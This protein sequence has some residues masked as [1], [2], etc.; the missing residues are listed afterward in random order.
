MTNTYRQSFQAPLNNVFNSR[1]RRA[2]KAPERPI[3]IRKDHM[4]EAKSVLVVRP[5]GDAQSAVAYSIQDDDGITMFTASGRKFG[6]RSCR[7]FRD[8]SGLPLFELHRKHWRNSWSVTLPGSSSAR[9]A[10]ISQRRNG[11]GNFYI[12]FENAGAFA[13]KDREDK[14]LTLEIE[15]HGN[16]LAMYDIVDGDRKVAE[17]RE[18]IQHNEKLALVRR[19]PSTK[20]NYRPVLDVIITA[21]VDLSL[22]ATV[23]VIISDAVFAANY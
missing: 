2:L 19:F 8:S 3:A 18:S 10:K 14:E 21:E 6:D 12:T 16:V 17:V 22:I 11:I 13:C 4:T 23:A 7:E 9:I 5:Q 1:I 15:S 20:H